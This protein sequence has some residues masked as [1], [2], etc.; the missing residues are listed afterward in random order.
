MSGT[1]TFP[2]LED[3]PATRQEPASATI[4]TLPAPS[5]LGRSDALKNAA[6]DSTSEYDKD[7]TKGP[8]LFSRTGP[9]S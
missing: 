7:T 6:H 3:P 5:T 2:A 4:A 1:A 8:A 9:F